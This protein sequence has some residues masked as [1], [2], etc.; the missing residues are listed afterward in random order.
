MAT[1]TVT[2]ALKVD[3]KNYKNKLDQAKKDLQELS[4]QQLKSNRELISADREIVNAKKRLEASIKSAD[5]AQIKADREALKGANARRATI[6]SANR[7]I[8]DSTKYM[9]QA[10][11]VENKSTK[12]IS[13]N[14]KERLKSKKATDSST[15]SLVRHLRQ[16]ETLIVA[17]YAVRTAFKNT[18]GIGIQVNRMMEDNTSGIAALLSANT[19][20]TLSNGKV[21]NSYDKFVIGQKLAA[22]TMED[23]RLASVKTYATFPQLTEIFQQAI[24]QTL[25]MGDSFGTTTKQITENTIKLSQRMSNIAGAI[26]MP[27]DRAKEEIRSLLSGNASTDSLISTMLFGSPGAANKAIRD[28]KARGQ[29]GMKDMLDGILKP[30]DVLAGVDSYTKNLLSLQDAWSNLMRKMSE[31]AFD[32]LKDIFKELAKDINNFSANLDNMGTKLE[33]AKKNIK[34]FYDF[35]TPLAT[36]PLPT[37]STVGL[38]PED[39]KKKLNNVKKLISDTRKDIESESALEKTTDF[40]FGKGFYDKSKQNDLVGYLRLKNKLQREYNVLIKDGALKTEEEEKS[41]EMTIV[42]RK[43]EADLLTKVALDEKALEQVKKF[44]KKTEDEI[45]KLMQ[46]KAEW[47]KVV[48][49]DNKKLNNENYK[50]EISQRAILEHRKQ[51]VDGILATEQ[52]I[53]E[54]EKKSQS[55]SNI[56]RDIDTTGMSA[57]TR[58]Q[59]YAGLFDI[60]ENTDQENDIQKWIIKTE[61]TINKEIANLDIDPIEI[62]FTGWDEVSNGIAGTLNSLSDMS[63]A[64]KEYNKIQEDT[65]STEDQKTKSS[66]A[67]G[68]SVMSNTVGMTDAMV[69]FYSEDDSR[70]KKQQKASEVF[71]V[72]QMAMQLAQMYQAG[73]LAVLTQGAGDP[74]TAFPRMAAMAALVASFGIMLSGSGSTP[75]TYE[76]IQNPNSTTVFGGGDE[77]STSLANSLETLED[78]AQPQF[79]ELSK[80]SDY[81]ESIEKN[82]RGISSDVIRTGGFALGEGGVNATSSYSNQP[83]SNGIA[84]TGALLGG[85]AGAGAMGGMGAM[86]ALELYSPYV[87]GAVAVDKLLDLGITDKIGGIVNSVLGSIGL[88]GGGYNWQQLSGSGIAFGNGATSGTYSSSEGYYGGTSSQQSFTPQT[89]EN[90]IEDFAGS[91]FQTQ[92]FESMSKSFWGSASYSYWSTTT[93]KELDK[94]LSNSL[95]RTFENIRDSIVLSSSILETDVTDRLNNMVVNIGSIDLKGL[96]GDALV[97]KLQTEFSAQSDKFVDALY[98]TELDNFQD[99]GEGLYETLIRVSTGINE[100][101]Y[102]TDRLGNS[103][104]TINYKD[105]I[106]T[107]GEV[108][109]EALLQSIIKADEATYGLSNG[110]VQMLSVMNTSAEDLFD[111]Y[112]TLET[113]RANLSVTG[114]DEKNLSSSFFVGAGGVQEFD[115]A[116]NSYFK[117][118]L[119]KAEQE[120]ELTRRLNKEFDKLGVNA[121]KGIESF[122]EMIENIDTTTDSG[123]ELYGRMILLSES[124]S[125]VYGTMEETGNVAQTFSSAMDRVKNSIIAGVSAIDTLLD[126]GRRLKTSAMVSNQDY[127]GIFSQFK[128]NLTKTLDAAKTGDIR[129]GTYASETVASS[130]AYVKALEEGASNAATLAFGKARLAQ[131]LSLVDGNQIDTTLDDINNTAIAMLG[132]DSDIVKWLAT[133]NGSVEDMT[134]QQYKDQELNKEAYSIVAQ[135]Q[136]IAVPF[137]NGGIV[138]KPTIGLIG[139]A[140]YNEAVI[141]LKNPNDPLQM[142]ALVREIRDL[143]EEN[144]QIKNIMIKLELN[145]KKIETNSKSCASS[146]INIEEE[147][148]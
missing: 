16:I 134:F 118:F 33:N 117:N 3:D 42:K 36:N 46:Q 14:T 47:Q 75:D 54:I 65:K 109:F 82:I 73:T 64:T 84:G 97:E 104:E 6:I 56:T 62:K 8:A 116:L 80:M 78:F 112:N 124:F 106:D 25:S 23:L 98:G 103:F 48:L 18:L 114:Q 110:V 38:D 43:K 142:S 5:K 127:T 24:G 68:Q 91:L 123:A 55:V 20:M 53:S 60:Y 147:V 96:S 101:K 102:Y 105:I 69:N 93:Y 29:N 138:T 13:R 63:K 144:R 115:D 39:I 59:M 137:A 70:R 31:P 12:A 45:T 34:S 83:F 107:K 128:D 87:L 133:I 57:D 74:Y 41:Y 4:N 146:L 130:Q 21:T 35:V 44:T 132:A 66:E 135:E 15:N 95:S 90:L 1:S 72:A 122:K 85:I 52:K 136:G 2:T 61:E 92:S 111:T 113:I 86:G 94:E 143:K 19:Q 129:A 79:R 51:I 145:T 77:T 131:E 30:F 32:A 121:P 99:I 119:S 67:Y 28:A 76:Q 11:E 89:L 120:A 126:E 141:P 9:Q 17:Y 88:G 37:A 7:A 81:L 40:M 26:G 148:A 140:G 50:N 27:M 10:V 71:H 22:Q 108:G 139:E 49:E 100:A 125:E 58:G